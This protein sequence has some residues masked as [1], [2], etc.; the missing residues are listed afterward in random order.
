MN[1]RVIRQ[2]ISNDSLFCVIND[3]CREGAGQKNC[4]MRFLSA[5]ASGGG[6]GAIA[7]LLDVFL[8]DGNTVEII[9]GVDRQGTDRG[10]LRHLNALSH[11]YPSQCRVSVFNAPARNCI[12]HPKLYIFETPKHGSVVFGSSNLTAGGLASNFESLI[13]FE[14]CDG[15]CAPA[16]HAEEIWKIFA[17][18]S[19]PLRSQFLRPLTPTYF[20]SLVAKLPEKLERD[21]LS[22]PSAFRVLWRPI[23]RVRLPSSTLPQPR[24]HTE[25]GASTRRYLVMDVL[26]ET[27]ETQM[28]VPLHVVEDFFQVNRRK[29]ADL[30]LSIITHTGLSQPIIRPIVISQGHEGQRLMRRIEM[31]QIKN[32]QR[33]LAVAFLQLR[34]QRRF[35]FTLLPAGSADYRKASR[36]LDHNGQQGNAQ[37]RYVIGKPNDRLWQSV[38]SFLRS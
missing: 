5:F 27:R 15:K 14:D 28:Q 12:F 6:V 2:S 26:T 10:A 38:K 7:P 13:H 9:V 36:L 3:W 30:R 31:P 17:E 29:P 11:A 37:R 24:I 35:A 33:P 34:G 4:R 21:G 16:Q 18:P 19:H 8:A 25:F 23:S 1:S 32:L 22:E 20:K